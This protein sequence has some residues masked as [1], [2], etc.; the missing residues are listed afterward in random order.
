MIARFFIAIAPLLMALGL[1]EPVFAACASPGTPGAGSCVRLDNGTVSNTLSGPF[2][3]SSFV[4]AGLAPCDLISGGCA[5]AYSVTRKVRAAYSGSLFRVVRA[6][7][8]STQDIGVVAPGIVDT[9]SLIS[10]CMPSSCTVSILY[11]QAGSNNLVQAT[12]ANRPAIMIGD[13]QS[14][15]YILTAE[16]SFT[17]TTFLDQLSTTGLPTGGASKTIAKVGLAIY[18]RCCGGFGMAE[19]PIATDGGV[20]EPGQMFAT[21]LV[22][23][24]CGPSLQWYNGASAVWK[25]CVDVEGAS[26]CGVIAPT[27]GIEFEEIKFTSGSN[28]ID[29]FFNGQAVIGGSTP[30]RT[31]NTGNRVVLGAAG[32]RAGADAHARQ[33][34]EHARVGGLEGAEVVDAHHAQRRRAVDGL[35]HRGEAD[36]LSGRR[37]SR[38]VADEEVLG[39]GQPRLLQ[40]GSAVELGAARLHRRGGVAGEAEDL[41]EGGRGGGEGGA[42]QCMAAHAQGGRRSKKGE[43]RRSRPRLKGVPRPQRRGGRARGAGLR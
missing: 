26:N 31:I 25:F 33:L 29:T 8:S 37:Q 11:D 3:A 13:A 21:M 24:C 20:G 12:A 16:T 22:N 5:S 14:L 2:I 7:D 41:G 4:R 32:E 10:F 1:S 30:E 27:T 40:L 28:T 36:V 15:P 19:N 6:S 39:R 42:G 34:F 23:A 38:R 43:W 35:D 17:A 18:S 9:D